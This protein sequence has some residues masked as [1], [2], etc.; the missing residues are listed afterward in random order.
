MSVA[1]VPLGSQDWARR[2]DGLANGG[3]NDVLEGWMRQQASRSTT[4][5]TSQSF[6]E[7]VLPHLDAARRLA[8]WLM[9][10][11]HDAEDALQEAAL[12][13]FRTSRPF[14]A[15]MGARGFSA[16][17]EIRAAAGARGR[18]TRPRIRS[19]SSS[20]AACGASQIRKR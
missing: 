16:S 13:A 8:R 4:G 12:R 11:E 6:D 10:N 15:G 3:T 1:E 2:V 18:S 7:V 17:F 14:P 20:T 5:P 9:R 19:M